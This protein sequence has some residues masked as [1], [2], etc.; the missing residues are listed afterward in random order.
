MMILPEEIELKLS[1][2]PFEDMDLAFEC[3]KCS[4]KTYVRLEPDTEGP[5][6]IECEHCQTVNEVHKKKRIDPFNVTDPFNDNNVTGFIH[7]TP[8]TK[9]GQLE[10]ETVNGKD[11]YQVIWTTPKMHYPMDSETGKFRPPP[12]NKIEIYEKLDGC[13]A[14]DTTVT[15]ELGKRKI[16]ELST[17]SKKWMDVNVLTYNMQTDELEFA[18]ILGSS[19][20]PNKGMLTIKVKKHHSTRRSKPHTIHVT[21]NHLIYTQK[22]WTPAEELD[23]AIDKAYFPYDDI[24][25][26]GKEIIFGCILGD[27]YLRKPKDKKGNYGNPMISIIHSQ[28]QKEYLLL[29]YRLMSSICNIEPYE[30]EDNSWGKKKIRMRT[31]CCPCLSDFG[32]IFITKN[33]IKSINNKIDISHLFTPI[34]IAFWFMDDGAISYN[35]KPRCSFHVQGLSEGSIKIIQS[36]LLSKYGIESRIGRYKSGHV[37]ELGAESTIR[38][39]TLISPYITKSMQYKLPDNL[40]WEKP[41]ID[42]MGPV[43]M[44]SSIVE[45]DIIDVKPYKKK[46][47][48]NKYQYDLHT[49]N[50]NYFA[51]D[52]LVHNSNIL[53]FTYHDADGKVYTSYKTRLM[54]FLKES[55]KFGDFFGMWKEMLEKYPNIPTLIKDND[56]NLSFELYGKRNKVMV[57]YEASLDCA[58]LFGV[59][60]GGI[61]IPP[62]VLNRT[63]GVPI[64]PLIRSVDAKLSV[65][66]FE[67]LYVEVTEYL[68]E[69]L[70]VEKPD[71]GRMQEMIYGME[72]TVWYLINDD[73]S[74]QEKC[75]GYHSPIILPNGKSE[76]IGK[77]VKRKYSG[78]VL[79]YDI[80][81]DKIVEKGVVAHYRVE[82]DEDCY[83]LS[84]KHASQNHHI[85]LTGK[86]PVLTSNGY[87]KVEDLN[88]DDQ[89]NTG[90]IAPN[91]EQ[92]SILFGTLLGDGSIVDGY[93]CV[94]FGHS[95]KQKDYLEYKM[96]SL[97]DLAKYGF[98]HYNAKVGDSHYRTIKS[99]TL[100]SK[101]FKWLR[102]EFY[103]YNNDNKRLKVVPRW[104]R[105]D[106]ISLAFWYMDDGHKD[107]TKGLDDHLG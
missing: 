90:E 99:R 79:S 89:I 57:E 9:Y 69:N 73:G 10:I 20:I 44:Q 67:N 104:L 88:N 2:E 27:G 28:K 100:G 8:N 60:E 96:D 30:Y 19:K 107:K 42:Q 74:V 70:K 15:T 21:A 86:H 39:L 75:L 22:G 13:L 78:N 41:I 35:L 101:Y 14:Y 105:L 34:A 94:K 91:K 33:N 81:N 65:K 5:Y 103:I 51:N 16:G 63:D 54:P 92:E 18:P 72:G 85:I 40:C 106:P 87:K 12:S 77:L 24:Q 17:N 68:N 49:L 84:Y 59:K 76:K 56:C 62:S 52:I 1:V 71:D 102:D 36:L 66:E 55:H 6:E 4:K 38:L 83:R 3:D 45:V 53:G 31:K 23:S 32:A 47:S 80:N 46:R 93:T 50:G 25:H 37:L 11:C 64:C 82:N 7:K 95:Y 43:E 26:I 98:T 29:K 48:V 97:G 61:I 58:L